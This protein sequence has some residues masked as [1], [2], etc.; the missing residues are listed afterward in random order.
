MKKFLLKIFVFALPIIITA[1]FIDV[2]ISTNLKKSNGFAFKEYT[3]WNAV[4]DGKLEADV[5][6]YG[7]SRAWVHF[8]PK[9]IEDSLNLS[10][11][12]L[13]IDGNTFN[14]QHLRHKLALKH[15]KQPKLIIHS[16]DVTTLQKGNFFNSKQILPYMLW[17]N[18]F[19]EATSEYPN[20][21]YFDYKLPLIRYQSK[22]DAITMA[23]N[24]SLGTQSN[25]PERIKGYEGQDRTW[26]SDFKKAKK[27]MKK[28]EI[29][30]DSD[31]EQKF[32][33]YLKECKDKNI[34]VLFVYSP[35]YIEGQ[36]FIKNKE[37]ILD[38][39]KSLAEAYD[40]LFFDFSEDELCYDKKY[41]YNARHLNK[42]GAEI[43]SRKVANL[44]KKEDVL[45]KRIHN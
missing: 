32:N 4:L 30:F 14:M 27:K 17:N 19:F 10:V 42:Q 15:N 13:G 8:D 22:T 36:E 2:F 18:D 38:Y 25:E 45:I 9:I 44:I 1:Y 43:F 41:F 7:S 29:E 26:N 35:V 3:T 37:G 33:A 21:S 24:M 23:L 31:L 39:Y 6:I 11:Y 5:L 12:N 20:Y 28:Y 34:E 16:I 40:F